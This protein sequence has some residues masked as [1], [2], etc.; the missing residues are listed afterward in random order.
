MIPVCVW[1]GKT[2]S[3][4][5]D[6]SFWLFKKLM[7]SKNCV[8]NKMCKVFKIWYKLVVNLTNVVASFAALLTCLNTQAESPHSVQRIKEMI[9][10]FGSC[11]SCYRYNSCQRS[12]WN[13]GLL[14]LTWGPFFLSTDFILPFVISSTACLPWCHDFAIWWHSNAMHWALVT[15]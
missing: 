1:P 7:P 10:F 3:L 11:F 15:I 8:C 6:L 13:R 12:Q 5:I 4:P 2:H 14:C 9:G